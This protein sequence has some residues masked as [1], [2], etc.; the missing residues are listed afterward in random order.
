M[1]VTVADNDVAPVVNPAVAV[2]VPAAN[3]AVAAI[4]VLPPASDT[5]AVRVDENVADAANV[6]D[7]PD[8]EALAVFVP[9]ANDEDAASVVF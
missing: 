3:V 6:V 1:N 9:A 7:P 2:F 5:D 8:S 4:V